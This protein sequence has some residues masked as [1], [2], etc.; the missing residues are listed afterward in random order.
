MAIDTS[1]RSGKLPHRRAVV[2]AMGVLGALENMSHD[3]A[4]EVTRSWSESGQS[5]LCT[6]GD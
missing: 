1:D 6:G 3:S 2:R 5:A 4:V